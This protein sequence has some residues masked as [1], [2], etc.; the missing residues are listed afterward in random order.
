MKDIE[1]VESQIYQ[2]QKIV[3]FDT[4]EFTIEYIINK[5]LKDLD[6]DENEIYV[7]EYQREF[8]WDEIRQS[9]LIESIILGLPIPLIFLA[10][11]KDKDN[12]LEIV[13]GSQ[14]IRTLA[15]FV[16]NELTITGLEKLEKLNGFKFEELSNSRK[17]K[18]KNT[19]LRM[20]VLS[21]KATE[22]V[23]NEIFERINRGSDLLLAMEK[24]KGI[25]RGA[26]RDFIYDVCSKNEL[27]NKLTKVDGRQGR[28]Q[29]KEELILRFFALA[30]NY[31]HFPARTGV[32][33]FL[34][35]YL[36]E[37][38]KEFSYLKYKNE[39]EIKALAISDE[40][41]KKYADKFENMLKTVEKY[42][43]FGFSKNHIPQVSRVFFEAI[44]VGID[45]ALKENPHFTTTRASV[46]EWVNSRDFKDIISGR[47]HT[48]T[49]NRIKQRI[50][51]V[52]EKMLNK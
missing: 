23:R 37:K 15:A 10:E 30:D 11:N 42:F 34:D 5:Y 35:D 17:R 31:K 20:I 3:D 43:E 26:F 2:E 32:A 47:Y 50:E 18:F 40:K 1:Q 39:K 48:H 21:D 24:R 6:I 27:F 41:L 12:R 29:E 14:R 9:K 44:S 22:E 7:P 36:D 51:F 13:D 4:R 49:P 8:V 45:S 38:N 52:K 19:P 25:Y 16:G 33:K 46:Q 28:R